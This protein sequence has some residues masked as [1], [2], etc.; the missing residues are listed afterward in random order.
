MVESE[1]YLPRPGKLVEG[2]DV[3]GMHLINV[4]DTFDIEDSLNKLTIKDNM[5]IARA[6]LKQ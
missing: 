1:K 6:E 3:I 5:I 2:F 4:P